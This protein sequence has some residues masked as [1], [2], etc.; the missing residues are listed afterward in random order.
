VLNEE[1]GEGGKKAAHVH[2][3]LNKTE[4]PKTASVYGELTGLRHAKSKGSN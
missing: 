1:L 2:R 4:Q 3:N